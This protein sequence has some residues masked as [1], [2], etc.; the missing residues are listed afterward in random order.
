MCHKANVLE[1][2]V[3]DKDH[4]YTEEIGK[5]S[6]ISL[7]QLFFLIIEFFLLNDICI[8]IVTSAA[9]LKH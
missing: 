2:D 9:A 4:A 6:T 7:N 5:V 3:R 8:P 1:F